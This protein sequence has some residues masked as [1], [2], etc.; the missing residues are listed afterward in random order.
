MMKRSKLF[1]IACALVAAL[2]LC[3]VVFIALLWAATREPDFYRETVV[4]DQATLNEKADDFVRRWSSVVNMMQRS[5]EPVALEIPGE[6]INAWLQR[7]LQHRLRKVLPVSVRNPRL[8][9][10][11]DEFIL[12]FETQ[13]A[14]ANWV[15]S[16]AGRAWLPSPEWLA[17]EIRKCSIGK[18]PVPR[19]LVATWLKDALEDAG[20][21][22]DLRERDGNPTLLVALPPKNDADIRLVDL[23]IYRGRLYLSAVRAERPSASDGSQEASLAAENRNSQS[24]SPRFVR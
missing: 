6:E 18:L 23:R 4:D 12:G 3:T 13:A 2:V 20:V 22:G 17:I 7:D 24:E 11:D 14:G 21:S 9:L 10:T 1:R 19:Q 8:L 15:V 16:L 5:R